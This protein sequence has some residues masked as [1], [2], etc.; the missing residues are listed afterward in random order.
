MREL[1]IACG[2]S[3]KTK[4]WSNQT[5]G[6]DD[7]CEKLKTTYR[8]RETVDEYRHMGRAD[9]EKAKDQGGF[10][11]GY[12]K[13]GR[14]LAGNVECRSF[15]SLDGDNVGPGFLERFVSG[16]GYAAVLYTTHSHTPESPRVRILIPFTEDISPDCYT[17][18][19]G[20]Y[21]AEWGIDRFDP[22]SFRVNQMMYWPTTP[23]DGEYICRVVDGP[24]MDAMEFLGKYPNWRDCS[25]IPVSGRETEAWA[26][27]GRKQE[28][29]L[30]KKG[31]VGTFCRAYTIQAAIAKFLPDVYTESAAGGRYDY[32]PGEGT[33]GVVVYDNRFA[34]S[35]H[36]TDPAGGRLLNAFD[37][38]RIHKFGDEDCTDSFLKMRELA[39]SDSLV[40]EAIEKEKLAQARTE[41]NDPPSSWEEPIP[42][43][44]YELAEFPTDALPP[45]IRAFVE[46][47]AE[48]TQTPV[49]MAGTCV[50]A[51]MAMCCQSKYVV[52][53]KADWTEPL[54]LYANVIAQPS[55]RKSAV[56]N[57]AIRPADS[58]EIQYN[59]RNASRVKESGMR[60]RILERR[61]KAVEEK[62]AKGQAEPGELE[63]V[64]RE[65]AEFVEETPLH[66]Y[67]DDIT[68][69]KLVS[70]LASNHG[71]AAL[72][73]SEGGI[74]DTLAGIYT[75][76]VN[77]D[78]MLKAYSGDT[79][80]VD[81]I[82]RESESIMNPALT[83]LLM[84]Q[85]KVISDVFGNRTFRGR[86][87]TA[88]FLYCL[89]DSKVG[90]RRFRSRPVPEDVYQQYEQKIVNMLEEEYPPEPETITLSA[91]ASRLLADFAEEIE[92]KLKADYSGIADW[93]G[94]L[95]G[96]T[97]RIAGILCR[98]GV[99]RMPE[100]LDSN[101]PLV[102]SG[103][104]MADAIKLGRYYLSHALAVY[105]AVPQSDL[106]RQAE[107][108]LQALRER[109][110][111]NF[112]RREAM[113]ICQSFKRA[114][115]IQ[116]VLDF[117]EDL[118]YIA[119][120]DKRPSY[121]GGRPPLP[122]YVT[123]PFVLS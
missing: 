48:S 56:E 2:I 70:V 117:L 35:H 87:L 40:R 13:D 96:N 77:I 80:R 17:A 107:K 21:A 65:A 106:Y 108:I 100:F 18:V 3:S 11:G 66:L 90:A 114:D 68:T 46:A 53:G 5:M 75:R 82:G 85:P 6:W 10:V 36:A 119:S 71:H 38:V 16:C 4:I 59:K 30:S 97:L 22:C 73:S 103:R 44:K 110:L 14:R 29:P 50:L 101:D 95:V 91:E 37:L 105:G 20:Y 72:I 32:I 34:Y 64:A 69:E 121:G 51:V 55:E 92:P 12:L 41:F 9:R 24:F 111:A 118:G 98:A 19:A 76:N 116:P 99:S 63:Q 7:L 45:D 78:V 93:A 8:T 47:A 62:V 31:I 123:N 115:E 23:S 122:K 84:A 94:K 102:V 83:V 25:A 57:L 43:G 39:E 54:N 79:I 58:F 42:F 104:T 60:K 28:D 61:Q 74:F 86:G 52:R 120:V 67:V 33:A 88:R 26:D 112:N 1:K 15:L 113:R 89:P 81:R 109:K 27:G 49:D